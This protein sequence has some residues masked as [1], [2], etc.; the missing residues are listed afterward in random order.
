NML[1]MVLAVQ[2]LVGL[3]L[4]SVAAPN[5]LAEERARGSL[6]V[7][8]ATPLS[9]RSILGGKWWGTYRA[10][11]RLAFLPSLSAAAIVLHNFGAHLEGMLL[12]AGL[13]LAYGA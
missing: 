13:I 10:V 6:D 11:P 1:A 3:L 12:L 7:L 4:V 9:T 8:L 5:P 2:V